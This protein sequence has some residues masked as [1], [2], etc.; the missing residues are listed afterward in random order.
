MAAPPRSLVYTRRKVVFGLALGNS[1]GLLALRACM[2][3]AYAYRIS[4]EGT[5]IVG[6][7]WVSVWSGSRW[8]QHEPQEIGKPKYNRVGGATGKR[9]RVQRRAYC[10]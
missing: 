9:Q 2:G 7:N 10:F 8:L 6:L 1:A 3:P 5:A 4:V